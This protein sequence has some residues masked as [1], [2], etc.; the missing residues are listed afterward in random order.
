MINYSSFEWYYFD[1][2][3][4]EGYDIVC[5]IH[6]RP[7]NSI[8]DISIFDIFVY[9][10]NKTLFHH[11]FVKNARQKQKTENPF[12]FKYDD[13]NYIKKSTD[14]IEVSIMDETVNFKL[15]F[16]DILK[17]KNPP[18]NELIGKTTEK[19]WFNWIVYAPLCQGEIKLSWKDNILNVKGSGYHDYNSGAVNLKQVLEK[20]F[21]GKY[22][23][24]KEL[25]I[26]GEILARKGQLRKIALLVGDNSWQIIDDPVR[27]EK[28]GKLYFYISQR[29]F[30]FEMQPKEIIDDVSFYMSKLSGFKLI[31][32]IVEAFYHL[33]SKYSMPFVSKL[34]ANTR[35]TRSRALGKNIKNKAVTCFSEEMFL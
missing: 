31:V 23:F 2:H 9:K 35:Y 17:I 14:Q 10:N 8:F 30:V 26:Y 22:Y 6:P 7:F 25:L 32:K 11:F 5:T 29:E 16:K 27:E 21:W 19:S 34:I 33:S 13:N 20:W 4:D 3:T 12:I 24:D 18:V 28:N 1:L 15:L